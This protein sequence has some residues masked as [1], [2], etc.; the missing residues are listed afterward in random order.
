MHISF[1]LVG[2]F[3]CSVVLTGNM[4]EL[5]SLLDH[6]WNPDAPCRYYGNVLQARGN[7][8]VPHPIHDD[9]L[10]Q[11]NGQSHYAMAEMLLEHAAWLTEDWGEI[12][13]LANEKQRQRDTESAATVRCPGNPQEISSC[14][15]RASEFRRTRSVSVIL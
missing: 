12:C 5:Q 7:V 14:A 2:D 10:Y 8:F 15:R 4:D 9:P 1:A 3:M 11:E 13:Y 6:G